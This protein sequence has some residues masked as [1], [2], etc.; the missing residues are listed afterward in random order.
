MS[1]SKILSDNALI[2]CMEMVQDLCATSN[3]I[4]SKNNIRNRQ[5]LADMKVLS[6]SGKFS[7]LAFMPDMVQIIKNECNV[8]QITVIGDE[9]YQGFVV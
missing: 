3:A 2:E 7:F 1:L 4:R 9:T 6:P 8:K 5:P